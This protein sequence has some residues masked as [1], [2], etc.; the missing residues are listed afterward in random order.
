MAKKRKIS[1]PVSPSAY[2]EAATPAM[3]AA[4]VSTR[5][6]I[7]AFWQHLQFVKGWRRPPFPLGQVSGDVSTAAEIIVR[8]RTALGTSSITPDLILS[9][10]TLC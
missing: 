4:I 3:T 2:L 10:G 5:E 7:E 1:V 6:A 8:I 9:A